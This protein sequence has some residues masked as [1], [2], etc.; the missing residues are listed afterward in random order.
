M[1]AEGNLYCSIRHRQLIADRGRLTVCSAVSSGAIDKPA[2]VHLI[3]PHAYHGQQVHGQL[4]YA[5]NITAGASSLH[6]RCVPG[7]WR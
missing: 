1:C 3:E 5:V 4:R 6:N 2:S 7:G